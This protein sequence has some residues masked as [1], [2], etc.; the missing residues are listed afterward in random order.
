[1]KLSRVYHEKTKKMD[2]TEESKEDVQRENE[3][4][5]TQALRKR[6]QNE[7]KGISEETG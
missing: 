7:V 3:G 4:S 5:C 1:M 2:N 6:K